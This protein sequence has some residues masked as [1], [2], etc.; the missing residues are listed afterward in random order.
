MMILHDR[1]PSEEVWDDQILEF[2]NWTEITASTEAEIMAE[3]QKDTRGHSSFDN[4]HIKEGMIV[5]AENSAG[6][7]VGKLKSW[8]FCELEGIRPWVDPEDVE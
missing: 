5:R 2:V 8:D 3:L 7:K 4:S 6:T 1:Y